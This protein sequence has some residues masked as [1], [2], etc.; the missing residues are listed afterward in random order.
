[1]GFNRRQHFV[2]TILGLLASSVDP[3]THGPFFSWKWSFLRV[4][5]PQGHKG[6]P[7]CA[8]GKPTRTFL[9]R[10]GH[11]RLAHKQ[12]GQSLHNSDPIPR[13]LFS[14]SSFLGRKWR[15]GGWGGGRGL[16]LIFIPAGG[17]DPP[18]RTPSPPPPSAQVHPK[19]WVLGTFFSHG[20]KISAPSVHAIYCVRVAPRVLH[21]PCLADHHAPTLV[22][23]NL[24]AMAAEFRKTRRVRNLRGRRKDKVTKR[25]KTDVSDDEVPSVTESEDDEALADNLSDVS[26]SGSDSG[27]SSS[28]GSSSG[29][30]T[31]GGSSSCESNS[32]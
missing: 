21:I 22:V 30:T 27:S 1:M 24:S 19:T 17:G 9:S 3:W 28:S 18:P 12:C 15:G 20:E 23:S 6:K 10:A 8:P 25:R 32:D 4:W 13:K 26:H 14:T 7:V 29:S 16:A 5:K 31:D 11:V 2:Q